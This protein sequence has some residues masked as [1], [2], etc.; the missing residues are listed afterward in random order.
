MVRERLERE[1]LMSVA[2]K[3]AADDGG[4]GLAERAHIARWNEHA[5]AGG[6]E[7]RHAPCARR[8]DRYSSTERLQDRERAVFPPDRGQR[9]N[10]DPAEHAFLI[11]FRKG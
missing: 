3:P 1:R 11:A 9:Q 8:D 10:V 7:L 5:A 4:E 6:Q 2:Q